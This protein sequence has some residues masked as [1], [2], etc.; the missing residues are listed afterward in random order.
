MSEEITEQQAESLLREFAKDKDSVQSFFR[1]VIQSDD[2]TK[3][4]N[5]DI[6]ELGMPG[7]PLRSAKELELFCRDVWS[8]D[9]WANYFKSL[10][11]IHTSTSLSKDAILI[12]LAVTKKSEVADVTPKHKRRNSGWFTKKEE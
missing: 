10:A 5:L 8:Q 9:C 6:D 11:E 1:D 3:T 2:T 7:L 12:K 4:G